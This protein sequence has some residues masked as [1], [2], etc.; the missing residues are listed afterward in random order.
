MNPNPINIEEQIQ[1][2]SSKI[3][4]GEVAVKN[5]TGKDLLIF[6]GNTGSGKSTSINYLN[7]CIMESFDDNAFCTKVRVHEKSEIPSITKIG[8]TNV[9]ETEVP[10]VIEGKNYTVLDCPGFLDN[11]GPLTN[12]A[13]AV[14]IRNVMKGAKS[15]KI[16]ITVGF[17]KLISDR[18]SGLAQMIDIAKKLF[19]NEDSLIKNKDSIAIAVTHINIDDNKKAK[20]VENL[21]KVFNNSPIAIKLVNQV[22]SFDPLDR[23]LEGGFKLNQLQNH[24]EK[25]KPII[26]CKNLFKTVLVP[27]D[28][29]ELR[30]IQKAINK[31]IETHMDMSLTLL[32]VNNFEESAKFLK[33]LHSLGV[34][35]HPEIDELIKE[36]NLKI[37]NKYN[38]LFSTFKL[39]CAQ[40]NFASADQIY[41]LIET[42]MKFFNKDIQNNICLK[43]LSDFK[44][45]MVRKMNDRIAKERAQQ[46]IINQMFSYMREDEERKQKVKI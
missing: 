33:L 32:K 11:R 24:I 40:E 18:D 1:L 3:T 44:N 4:A 29:V 41:K 39:S 36:S 45:D 38:E 2:I 19:G 42:S 25:I 30:D 9:S 28:I 43:E 5:A 26:D 20:N 10:V 23:P 17:N 6:I 13:N 14:N 37:N 31:K 46:D 27:S 7:G 12:I 35:E 22:I 8:H 21:K 34:I 16:V 15:V